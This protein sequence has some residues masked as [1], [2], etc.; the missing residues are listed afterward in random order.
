M[1][2]HSLEDQAKVDDLIKRRRTGQDAVASTDGGRISQPSSR[3]P[4]PQSVEE[5]DIWVD[6]QRMLK[7]FK[8]IAAIP[9]K[10]KH[11]NITRSCTFQASSDNW[12]PSNACIDMNSRRQVF[13]QVSKKWFT[14]RLWERCPGDRA[15]IRSSPPT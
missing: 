11:L 5:M 14:R 9:W 15:H 2:A 3:A 12:F 10:C 8:K 7:Y 6:T 1:M 4:S 13:L